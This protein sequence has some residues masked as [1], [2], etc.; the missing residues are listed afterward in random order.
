MAALTLD[1]LV[2]AAEAPAPPTPYAEAPA[3]APGP[4]PA[5]APSSPS[6]MDEPAPWSDAPTS[7]IEAPPPP[8]PAASPTSS[9][10]SAASPTRS[11]FSSQTRE[12]FDDEDQFDDGRSD[13]S[14][15]ALSSDDD[16]SDD[17]ED[18]GKVPGTFRDVQLH[19]A[20][21]GLTL[22]NVLEA[23]VVHDVDE[24]G[25]AKQAGLVADVLVVSV[26]GETTRGLLHDEVITLLR[27]P[28]RPLTLKVQ[29]LD[30][31]TLARRRKEARGLALAARQP[32]TSTTSEITD[33]ILESAVRALRRAGCL[34]GAAP[35]IPGTP[36]KPDSMAELASQLAALD[37]LC[38]RPTTGGRRARAS[39]RKH[40]SILAPAL[41]KVIE[42][43]ANQGPFDQP[44]RTFTLPLE[45]DDEELAASSSAYAKQA[46]DGDGFA[47]CRWASA[48]ALPLQANTAAASSAL[49]AARLLCRIAALQRNRPNAASH[50]IKRLARLSAL[51][52][53]DAPASNLIAQRC[54]RACAALAPTLRSCARPRYDA[55]ARA[56]VSK[57]ARDAADAQ[58]RA[59]FARCV[60]GF[61]G[62]HISRPVAKFLARQCGKFARDALPC[63]RRAALDACLTLAAGLPRTLE[64]DDESH[65]FSR[66]EFLH[67]LLA[68][69]IPIALQLATDASA[70][71]RAAFARRA[72]A[73]CHVFEK[74]RLVVA[75]EARALLEDDDTNVRSAAC[76]AIPRIAEL[77][78]EDVCEK[79]TS[80]LTPA[81]AA[82]ASDESP[83]C[84]AS[85]AKTSGLLLQALGNDPDAALKARDAENSVA[86]LD[87]ALFPLL[88]ILVN[89]EAP[90]VACTALRGLADCGAGLARVLA[91][92]HVDALTN[93][94]ANLSTSRHWRVR[95]CA[96]RVAP[97]LAPAC[98]DEERRRALAE[99]VAKALDDVVAEVRSNACACACACAAAASRRNDGFWVDAPLKEVSRLGAS[100]SSRQRRTG[101]LLAR[102]LVDA[103]SSF[104]PADREKCR[105]DAAA[106][107]DVLATDDLP[108]VRMDAALLLAAPIQA[109]DGVVQRLAG[110]DDPDVSE[111]GFN[112][113]KAREERVRDDSSCAVDFGSQSTNM[114]LVEPVEPADVEVVDDSAAA[115][116]AVS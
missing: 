37:E 53:G 90:S 52:C 14:D 50:T 13:A 84:R 98:D 65:T 23:T 7:P 72:G 115:G 103:S 20:R 47:P 97:A 54:A 55:F 42:G 95:C 89:D 88:L 31:V 85:L 91:P 45:D 10:Y 79:L 25:A 110:D 107:A 70:E 29:D 9:Y 46:S 39:L 63:V 4:A 68:S 106:L 87:R 38:S 44:R 71:V 105:E 1:T 6:L 102:S 76:E 80:A 34:P 108:L 109:G 16:I 41:C 101:L 8:P 74:Q 75:D 19:A 82:L 77:S 111:A 33:P 40:E 112:A 81:A 5:P 86:P 73:L 96:G 104:A 43:G 99:V 67:L 12:L 51:A 57:G 61:C 26:N 49:S 22:E 56:C 94:L 18:I 62:G 66:E 3:P 32:P 78:D 100:E 92:R 58:A 30:A 15:V 11:V 64:D 24:D 69:L 17:P 2:P 113:L 35:P 83:D 48:S 27:T 93:S 59:C 28:D 114:D 21:L 60:G 116:A 36:S